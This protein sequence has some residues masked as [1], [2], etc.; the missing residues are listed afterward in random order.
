VQ[1]ARNTEE[2]EKREHRKNKIAE[3]RNKGKMIAPNTIDEMYR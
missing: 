2:K 3:Y 1:R